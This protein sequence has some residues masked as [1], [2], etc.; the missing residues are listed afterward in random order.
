MARKPN[1]IWSPWPGSQQKFLSCP[2]WECLL[3][4]PRGGGK[5]V[6]SSSYVATDTG[7]RRIDSLSISD[8]VYG[9]DAKLYPVTG[10][11][12]QGKKTEYKLTLQDGR[13]VISGDEHLWLVKDTVLKDKVVSTIE[14][15]EKG[16]TTGQGRSKCYKYRIPNCDPLNWKEKV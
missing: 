10:V 1:I 3:E 14:M 4:G 5:C 15:Y 6:K 12:P 16:I 7:W 13:E 8:M 11:F 2:V 9:Q